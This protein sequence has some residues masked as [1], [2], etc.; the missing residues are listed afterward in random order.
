MVQQAR[1]STA[2]EDG[3]YYEDPLEQAIRDYIAT[4]PSPAELAAAM[5]QYGVSADQ[6]SSA[7]GYTVEQ[8]NTYVAPAVSVPEPVY[9]A[10][11]APPPEPVYQA[12]VAELPNRYQALEPVAEEPIYTPPAQTV[13][14]PVAPPAP[15]PPPPVQQA[16]TPVAPVIQQSAPA[17]AAAPPPAAQATTTTTTT[18]PTVAQVTA[19]IDKWSADNT[20]ATPQQLATA[21]KNGMGLTAEVQQALANKYNMST[22]DVTAAYND[23]ITRP[24]EVLPPTVA[25]VTAAIDKWSAD[26]PGA[27]PAQLATAIKNGMGMTPEVTQALANKYNMSTQDVTA[28]YNDL[29]TKAEAPPTVTAPVVPTDPYAGVVVRDADGTEFGASDLIKLATQVAQNLDVSKSSGGAFGTKGENIGFDYGTLSSAY[30][31]K[32]FTA[33]DQVAFDIAR[34]LLKQGVTNYDQVKNA[35]KTTI[36]EQQIVGSGEDQQIYDVQREAYIDP[37]T[38]KEIRTDI[39]ATYTGKGNTQYHI[40]PTTGKFYTTAESSSDVSPEM[41]AALSIGASF[42]MPGV[43]QIL[44]A[45]LG[46]SINAA[47]ALANAGLQLAMGADPKT[48]LLNAGLAVSGV[49]K[50]IGNFT[51]TGLENLTSGLPEGL[52]T[53][54]MLSTAATAITRAGTTFLTTGDTATA[55]TAAAG[56]VVNDVVTDKTGSNVLGAGAAAYVQTGDLTTAGLVAANAAAFNAGQTY[57]KDVVDLFTGAKNSVLQTITAD[58][59]A[60]SG[61]TQAALDDLFDP[62][63]NPYLTSTDITQLAAVNN[64]GTITD[65][66]AGTNDSRVEGAWTAGPNGQRRWVEVKGADGETKYAGWETVDPVTGEIY[67]TIT[68]GGV[69]KDGNPVDMYITGIKGKIPINVD[70]TKS[71]TAGAF[72]VKAIK[73]T[74]FTLGGAA[75]ATPTA[76][77]AAAPGNVAASNNTT[78]LPGNIQVPGGNTAGTNVS[79]EGTGNNIITIGTGTGTGT[80]TGNGVVTIGGT[81]TGNGNANIGGTG[82]GNG[83]VNVGGT[84]T[85]NGVVNVGGTG[86]GNGN[87]NI[88]GTGNANIGGTDGNGIVIVG[89]TGNG[90][91]NITVANTTSNVST[92]GNVIS[93]IGNVLTDGNVITVLNTPNTTPNVSTPITTTLGTAITPMTFASGGLNPGWIAPTPFYSTT[94][95]AQSKFY[96]GSH[97][98]QTGG[99]TGQVF[100]PVLYNTVPAA[101]AQPWGSQAISQPLTSQQIAAIVANPGS[102]NAQ[103]QTQAASTFNP[104]YTPA[105]SVALT[106]VNI[107]TV[108]TAP[109]APP[110]VATAPVAPPPVATAPVAPPPVATAPVAPPP[111]ATTPIAP[112]IYNTIDPSLAEAHLYTQAPPPTTAIAPVAPTPPANPSYRMPNGQIWT[113]GSNGFTYSDSGELISPNP[114]LDIVGSY[115]GTLIA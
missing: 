4:N 76:N 111:V 42:L 86:T 23:L 91:A 1:Y 99:P 15:P 43:G 14:A 79:T 25:Q 35:Q 30:G 44:S 64:T 10:P 107:P 104:V 55:L 90:N 72:S 50:D 45:E 77:A 34:Q 87:A 26:N 98:Y 65:A 32:T 102:N 66:G 53:D 63:K 31:G 61:I 6:I 54:K 56:S 75:N 27:T 81:G 8:V 38:G 18:P 103:Q 48:V 13:S 5:Q 60:G 33:G 49:T 70:I 39:G 22:A 114:S 112:D 36:T 58:N 21:I 96:W 41:M 110:P 57:K 85:G 89:G 2:R 46:I 101:P 19:A 97:P 94:S 74:D 40:D 93:T 69:D 73:P 113:R 11:V 115:R 16:V 37:T 78:S 62:A 59:L 106:G 67:S 12:P 95:P 71:D 105:Q 88:G 108:A 83:V 29:I 7:T 68:S 28:S 20:G 100:D 84:G 9:Q 51:Q 47:N 3:S 52:I 82:T 24:P 80:G 92:V 17:A 109:V